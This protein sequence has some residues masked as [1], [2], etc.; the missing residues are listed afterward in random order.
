MPYKWGIRWGSVDYQLLRGSSSPP[1]WSWCHER[2]ST[3]GLAAK[4]MLSSVQ[5]TEVHQSVKTC[6]FTGLLAS[7]I[8]MRERSYTPLLSAPKARW[9]F[10]FCQIQSPDANGRS[11]P[12]GRT[13]CLLVVLHPSVLHRFALLPQSLSVQLCTWKQ[14]QGTM[15]GLTQLSACAIKLHWCGLESRTD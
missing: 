13:T 12:G 9:D 11:S 5:T 14:T 10:P 3:L 2:H 1:E 15:Y 8:W 6:C 7:F 4:E